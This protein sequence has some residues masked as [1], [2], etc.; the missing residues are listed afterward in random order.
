MQSLPQSE[1]YFVEE[2]QTDG[3][4]NL[5]RYIPL[6]PP[7]LHVSAYNPQKEPSVNMNKHLYIKVPAYVYYGRVEACFGGSTTSS[8]V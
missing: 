3:L 5:C 7:L 8:S 6:L 1:L 4:P 2:L